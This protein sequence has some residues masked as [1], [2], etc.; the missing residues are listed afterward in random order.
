MSNCGAR[1][2]LTKRLKDI[3]YSGIFEP[4]PVGDRQTGKHVAKA[5][6]AL[7]RETFEVSLS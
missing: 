2:S 6:N 4:L 5:H 1:V 7:Q 3:G